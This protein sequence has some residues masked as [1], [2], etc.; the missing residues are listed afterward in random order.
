MKNNKLLN[1]AIATPLALTTLSP[2]LVSLTSCNKTT[3]LQQLEQTTINEFKQL[4]KFPHSSD[5]FLHRVPNES[6]A[7]RLSNYLVQ[8]CKELTMN[9][10][11]QD[12][13]GNVWFDVDAND[14]SL[15]NAPTIALQAHMDMVFTYDPNQYPE[16]EEPDPAS[17]VIELVEEVKDGKRVIHSKDYK[18]TIGAD[19]GIGV[20][21][22]LA[23]LST[24]E[25][26]HG[27]LRII[28][29]NCEENAMQ[30]AVLMV[31][32]YVD[33]TEGGKY[34]TPATA[35][36]IMNN[37]SY[38]LNM[39]GGLGD[40]EGKKT[41]LSVGC[42]GAVGG[43]YLPY[44]IYTST[45]PSFTNRF[46]IKISG[47]DGGHSGG[48]VRQYKGNAVKA[49]AETLNELDPKFESFEIN[50]ITTPGTTVYNR[51]PS[52]CSI[53]LATNKTKEQI[54]T[55]FTTAINKHDGTTA[56]KWEDRTKAVCSVSEV[57]FAETITVS[58][59][60]SIIKLLNNLSYGRDE[61]E[62]A[63]NIKTSANIGPA[64]FYIYKG[65]GIFTLETYS[66]SDSDKRVEEYKDDNVSKAKTLGFCCIST[67]FPS[68]SGETNHKLLDLV[69]NT[70]KSELGYT[71]VGT[72]A[73]H[74][75]IEPAVWC[76][77]MRHNSFN[78]DGNC[79]SIGINV[80]GEH[81]VTE[82]IDVESIQPCI[83]VAMKVLAS[84]AELK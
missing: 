15:V 68:W 57:D 28:F 18:T 30:G 27:K 17:T 6:K 12:K 36:A 66:R 46:E 37:I 63:K 33:E 53:L 7:I 47:F 72:D 22:I 39:D 40:L 75:G 23:L 56:P 41:S 4:T 67:A 77:A 81:E 29:T 60:A 38:V 80:S 78:Y 2:V 16:G 73:G 71:E 65:Y 3:L 84:A 55:A 20:A 62:E 59:S 48:A 52:I 45:T 76:Y 34:T 5:K 25:V 21:A 43:Y 14:T 32:G 1:I 74:G 61:E 70:L 9:P 49:V 42:S 26:K 82:T 51:V 83:K 44:E 10:I 64:N 35:P 50:S 13:F 31:Q 58:D 69:S 79:V 54:E 8:R 19:N 11:Y 24:R